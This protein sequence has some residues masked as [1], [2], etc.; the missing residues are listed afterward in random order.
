MTSNG[1]RIKEIG[2]VNIEENFE[3]NDKIKVVVV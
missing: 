3:K 2:E 1:V